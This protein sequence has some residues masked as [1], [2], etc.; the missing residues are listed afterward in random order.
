MPSGNRFLYLVKL[1]LPLA[2]HPSCTLAEENTSEEEESDGEPLELSAGRRRGSKG[3]RTSSRGRGRGRGMGPWDAFEAAL[4][5]NSG[6]GAVERGRRRG[7]RPSLSGRGRGGGGR[8]NVDPGLEVIP[9]KRGRGR[10]PKQGRSNVTTV[11]GVV[12]PKR[13]RGRPPKQGRGNVN[14]DLGVIPPK[15]GRGRP[16]KQGRDGVQSQT[17]DV[18]GNQDSV[19]GKGLPAISGRG[20]PS[21]QKKICRACNQPRKGTHSLRGCP[22]HCLD[23]GLQHEYCTC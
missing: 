22:T 2:E 13:G 1:L 8:G 15:R 10:P 12:P 4:G 16:P 20:R 17:Q 18:E 19:V 3:G 23:C 9:P 5:G 6:Q 11:L 7:R 21:Q 14:S